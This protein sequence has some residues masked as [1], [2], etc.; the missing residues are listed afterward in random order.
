MGQGREQGKHE[1]RK[2]MPG[3][4]QL[5]WSKRVTQGLEARLY[6]VMFLEGREGLELP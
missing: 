3:R 4:A 6:F 5:M 1:D 2:R